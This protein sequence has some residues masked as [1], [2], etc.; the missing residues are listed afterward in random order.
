MLGFWSYRAKRP[1]GSSADNRIVTKGQ[2]PESG[3]IYTC[4]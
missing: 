1:K 2:I 4:H 3:E